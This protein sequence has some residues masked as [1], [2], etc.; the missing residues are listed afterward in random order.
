M[1]GQERG[2]SMTATSTARIAWIAVQVVE[3]IPA[4]IVNGLRDFESMLTGADHPPLVPP[5]E[6]RSSCSP[7]TRS[8]PNCRARRSQSRQIWVAWTYSAR[9]CGAEQALEGGAFKVAWRAARGGVTEAVAHLAQ[10]ANRG[11]ELVR[12]GAEQLSGRA[13]Q[14]T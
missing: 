10:L 4:W 14:W 12:L 5:R 6:V 2:P 1:D 7:E 3:P 11:V 9:R 13:D 8:R